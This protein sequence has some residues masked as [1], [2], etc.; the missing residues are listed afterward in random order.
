[1]ARQDIARLGANILQNKYHS[2]YS[3]YSVYSF[4]AMKVKILDKIEDHLL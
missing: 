2:W 4:S 3:R 1:M